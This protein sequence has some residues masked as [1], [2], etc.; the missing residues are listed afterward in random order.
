MLEIDQI[1]HFQTPTSDLCCLEKV[2]VVRLLLLWNSH[3]VSLYWSTPNI[4]QVQTKFK[5]SSVPDQSQPSE[6][7]HTHTDTFD[8]CFSPH[9][10]TD[11]AAAERLLLP[12]VL[13]QLPAGSEQKVTEVNQLV[14]YVNE[15]D[16]FKPWN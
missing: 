1:C 13:D 5:S 7:N 14:R 16:L 2:E 15:K 8:L 11:A 12:V 3:P 10:W 6:D 4:V 9:H